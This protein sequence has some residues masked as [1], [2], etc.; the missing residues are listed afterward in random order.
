MGLLDALGY[1][2]NPFVSWYD[3]NRNML[4][5]GAAGLVGASNLHDAIGGFTRGLTDPAAR[6]ADTAAQQAMQQQAVAQQ[7]V[8]QQQQQN[9][10]VAWLKAKGRDDLVAAIQGGMPVADAWK[11]YLGGDSSKSSY[12]LTPIWGT[13]ASGNPVMGQMSSSGGIQ[14]VQMPNGVTFG[15]EPIRLDAGDR[16]ILLDPVTR[17]TVGQIPKSGNV[18][19]GYQPNGNGIA[20]MPGSPA[21]DKAKAAAD[22]AAAQ[23]SA[24]NVTSDTVIGAAQKARDL[25][26][27]QW[28]V[29]LVGAAQG[30]IP[31]SGAAELRRQVA[32]LRST[33]SISAL[34]QMRQQSPTGGALGSVTEKEERML[35]DASGA[36]NPD[37]DPA[38]FLAQLDNYELTLLRIIHGYGPGT[39][40]FQQLSGKAVSSSNPGQTYTYNP[41]TGELE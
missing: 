2:S 35:A 13:D 9:A 22:Q 4:T 32:V 27:N 34:N 39:A 14:P 18:P 38:D 28:N 21:A 30:V 5:S 37:A 10:T 15:K 31:T 17:Q 16:F 24:A 8:A 3:Q 25:A 33:A 19:E 20:P 7:Q 29:G 11:S 6:Q 1:S 23:T 41:A 36:I 12:G 40:L 26:Q